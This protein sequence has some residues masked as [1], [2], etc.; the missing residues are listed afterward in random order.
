[1]IYAS[2]RRSD[3]YVDT[4]SSVGESGRPMREESAGAGLIGVRET[5]ARFGTEAVRMR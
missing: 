1:M 3:M 4:S 2:S 5:V